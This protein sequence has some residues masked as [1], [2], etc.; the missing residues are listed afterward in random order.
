MNRL[1]AELMRSMPGGGQLFSMTGSFDLCHG[2]AANLYV[3]R[4]FK[5]ETHDNSSWQ[6]WTSYI[7]KV[8]SVDLS[9]ERVEL[10]AEKYPWLP[11]ILGL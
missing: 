6:S 4:H 5:G 2:G 3:Y 10:S 8:N 7:Q 11:T 1:L 9:L